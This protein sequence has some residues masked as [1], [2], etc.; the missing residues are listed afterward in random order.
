VALTNYRIVRYE[1]APPQFSSSGALAAHALGSAEEG[2]VKRA[3]STWI[4][5]A[6]GGSAGRVLRLSLAIGMLTAGLGLALD[7]P[8]NVAQAKPRRT[9]TPTAT[10]SLSG[11]LQPTATPSLSGTVQPTATPSLS[12][13]VQPTATPSL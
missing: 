1:L 13:T 7:E 5:R 12:G 11:T 10:P 6:R 9:A 3:V 2:M 4:A 8:D